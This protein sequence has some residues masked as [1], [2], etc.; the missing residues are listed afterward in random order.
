[1]VYLPF[2]WWAISAYMQGK[3]AATTN[4]RDMLRAPFLTFLVINLGFYLLLYSLYLYDPTLLQIT[5]DREIAFFESEL[6]RG[7][8]DPQRSNDLREKIQ[9]LKTNGMQVPLGPFMLQMCMGAIGGFGLSALI[10]YFYQS[11]S[12]IS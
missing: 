4:F 11:R 7:T 10:A 1:L 2:M 3:N 8:G 12:R 5:T 6:A 9:Y